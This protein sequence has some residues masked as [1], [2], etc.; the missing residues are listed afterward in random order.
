MPLDTTESAERLRRSIDI[1]DVAIGIEEEELGEISRADATD[2]NTH[3]VVLLR[4][5]PK[6]VGN[7]R[8]E[9]AVEIT[10]AESEMQS[11]AH[12]PWPASPPRT[13]GRFA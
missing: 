2:H 7:Q 9:G 11:S 3:W 10:G 4:V 1:D 8:G 5:F 12:R 6:T 13:S